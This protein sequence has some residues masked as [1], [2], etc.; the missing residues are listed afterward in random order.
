MERIESIA[1]EQDFDF[2]G[3][4]KGNPND[5]DSFYDGKF[6][7][8]ESNEK[9]YIDG[10]KDN[11]ILLYGGTKY[12]LASWFY[13]SK[14]DFLFI[15][16][17][18]QFSLADC[19]SLGGIAT[20]IVLVGDQQQLGQPTQ[21]SHP[22]LSG[23]SVL[24]YLLEGK[25]TVPPDRGIFLT[26]THRMHPN[27][28]NFISENFYEN[29]LLTDLSAKSRKVNYPKNFYINND[30]IHTVLMNHADCSQT[31]EEEFKKIDEIIKK[32]TGQKF[33]DSDK[34][35][36]PLTISDFLIISPY[37]AQVN[38]LLERLPNGT[39]CGTIDRFQGQQAPITIISMTSSDVENLPRDKS[40][41][42]NRNRLN[43][44]IS[45]AQCSSIVLLNPRLLETPPKTLE[46]F[47]LINN[48]NKLLK[49]KTKLN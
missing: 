45:R 21:A 28:N 20:N 24:E 41:F 1:T 39:R 33:I 8:T 26:R 3:L 17:A 43:V 44:A 32:L 12:H 38:F 46:E 37:N 48:F 31:S 22:N 35:E 30:G 10:L 13:R 42:F 29:K 2:K 18:S 5:V 40:F 27:I 6:I 23:S 16:E 34:T 49:Y 25:D 14:I 47:K 36:R 9:K 19:I 11:K 7:K 15:E 4:K